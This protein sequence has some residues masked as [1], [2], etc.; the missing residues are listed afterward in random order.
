MTSKRP[1]LVSPSHQ[2]SP[3]PSPSL[4][5]VRSS[6]L[7]TGTLPSYPVTASPFSSSPTLSPTE[8]GS[9]ASPDLFDDFEYHED[10][11]AD[12]RRIDME[13]DTQSSQGGRSSPTLSDGASDP[14][15]PPTT[16]PG[17][18]TWV[19]FRGGAPGIYEDRYVALSNLESL[20]HSHGRF[21]IS[22]A[23]TTQGFSDAFQR[24]FPDRGSATA[25]WNTFAQD[26]TY[27]DYGKGPW[28][29][30]LG[31]KPGV[32]TKV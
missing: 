22:A 3:T 8:R 15:L 7:A 17:P 1:R 21:R 32:F 18:R 6:P 28:V 10:M 14:D 9:S 5:A 24:S 29:V 30:F 26:R 23:L 11:D 20:A 4:S 27:P 31:R 12:L 13:T 19:V 2:T 25:A 16:A